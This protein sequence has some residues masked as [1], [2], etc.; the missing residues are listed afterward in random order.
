MTF[1][2]AE[3]LKRKKCRCPL[4]SILLYIP[5]QS[6]VADT[7]PFKTKSFSP[8]CNT[9]LSQKVRWYISKGKWKLNIPLPNLSIV[10][11]KAREEMG[12]DQTGQIGS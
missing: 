11:F 2:N 7:G 5:S 10:T 12:K 6:H 4:E 8:K 1:L 3:F 9:T